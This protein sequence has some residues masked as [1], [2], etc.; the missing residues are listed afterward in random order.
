MISSFYPAVPGRTSTVQ[1]R[2]RMLYQLGSDESAIQNLQLQLSTGRRVNTPSD[3]LPAAVRA[4]GIQAAGEFKT[5]LKENLS[6]G[7]SFLSITETSLAQVQ[8]LLIQA[9]GTAV[10]AVDSTLSE[11]QREA[12]AQ[13]VLNSVQGLLEL[14]NGRFR[15]RYLFGGSELRSPPFEQVNN[16]V[17][18]NGDE[19]DLQTLS[20]YGSTLQ[21][22][23][24]GQSSF[25]VI[26]AEVTSSVDLNPSVQPSTRLEDLNAG[27]GVARG[28]IRISNG[29]TPV[30]ID[31]SHAETL[32][33]VA[34]ILNNTKIG[35]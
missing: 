20:D 14:G 9:R 30:E 2:Y 34:D 32:Q 31:L 29:L 10:S 18:Y 3:D 23:V 16:T 5:Q 8:N 27:A 22:N 6:T 17:R 33:D 21:I 35:I 19:L 7:Q 12:L 13:E 24:D 4:I 25:G 1:T 26:S 11:T 28:G 15:D